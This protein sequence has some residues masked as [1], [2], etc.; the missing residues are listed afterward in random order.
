M[1]AA[2]Q[3]QETERQNG[4]VVYQP[5]AADKV[6]YRG[7]F[8]VVDT[9]T[10]YA[11]PGTQ[12]ANKKFC[13]IAAEQADSTGKAAGAVNCRYHQQGIFRR[14]YFSTVPAFDEK[15]YIYDDST[16]GVAGETNPD[17]CVGTVT[18]VDQDAGEVE[19][20]IARRV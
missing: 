4:A 5:L 3:D 15:V 18:R 16:V 1:A 13:G 6:Q 7:T 19:F 12:A 8:G 20:D 10:N 14:P 2:T 9:T 11:E 17:I